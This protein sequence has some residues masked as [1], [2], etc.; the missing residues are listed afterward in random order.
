LAYA[1][2]G[3]DALPQN[4]TGR[5]LGS[6]RFL[7]DEQA[8]QI[9]TL[10]DENSPEDL[11]ITSALWTRRAVGELIDKEFHIDLAERT[12]GEYLRRWNYTPK[13]PQRHSH[14][15]D[16]DEVRQW[17]EKTYP[18]IEKRA[19]K[20]DAEIHWCD[21]VGVAADQHPGSGYSPKG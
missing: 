20:E 12:V 8:S 21:E 15:Q 5:P 13:K 11:G 19:A 1:S 3:L 2:D 18:A 17:L 4:R 6:G 9:R 16:P 10:I 7:S 14:K